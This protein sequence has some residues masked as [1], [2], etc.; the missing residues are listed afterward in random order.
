MDR[1]EHEVVVGVELGSQ[2]VGVV[3]KSDGTLLFPARAD[4]RG[5]VVLTDFTP[6]GRMID[7]RLVVVGRRLAGVERVVIIDDRGDE[8]EAVLADEGWVAVAADAGFAEPLARYED[9]DGGLVPLPLPDGRRSP[10][11]DAA[12]PCPVCSAVQWI[13]IRPPTVCIASAVASRSA[14]A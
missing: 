11:E 1:W 6:H 4:V 13:E 2:T 10:V 12:A 14:R 8:Y 5:G 9:A 7:G 3:R